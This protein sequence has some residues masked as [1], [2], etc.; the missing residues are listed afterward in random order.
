M[1]AIGVPHLCQCFSNESRKLFELT[2]SNY[3]VSS[4]YRPSVL[5]LA[6]FSILLENRPDPNWTAMTSQLE[7]LL[8]VSGSFFNTGKFPNSYYWKKVLFITKLFFQLTSTCFE[9]D[10]PIWI[11]I[12]ITFLYHLVPDTHCTF[13]MY[14]LFLFHI[15]FNWNIFL[16]SL[17]FQWAT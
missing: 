7:E 12:W 16:T 14:I 9:R 15:K 2:F 10:I 11:Q 3:G 17:D 1:L 5:A 13:Q 8:G 4:S 6:F